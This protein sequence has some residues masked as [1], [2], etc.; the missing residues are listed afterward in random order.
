M[1]IRNQNKRA[2]LEILTY[3]CPYFEK[4]IFHESIVAK[5]KS[6]TLT[7]DDIFTMYTGSELQIILLG[8]DEFS[9]VRKYFGSKLYTKDD[10]VLGVYNPNGMNVI[11][12]TIEKP[13]AHDEPP[14]TNPAPPL[15]PVEPSVE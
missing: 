9:G 11:P 12:T 10:I 5:A 1:P 4:N 6:G 13:V 14:S 8:Y 15:A 3:K 7:L 2:V